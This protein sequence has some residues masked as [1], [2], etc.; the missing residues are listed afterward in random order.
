MRWFKDLKIRSKLFITFAVLAI[1]SG[2]VGAVGI[3]AMKTINENGQKIY[4]EDF[5]PSQNLQIIRTALQEVRANQLWVVYER[6]PETYPTRIDTINRLIEQ[7]NELLDDYETKIANDQDRK[8]FDALKSSLEEY[9]DTRD[10]SLKLI[11]DQK[12]EEALA[13][14][15]TV[16]ASRVKAD[17]A[18][19]AL[20]DFRMNKINDTLIENEKSYG[21]ETIIMLSF[22]A[23]GVVAALILGIYLS[24]LISKPINKMVRAAQQLAVGDINVEVDAT[25]KDEVGKLAEAFGIMIGSIRRQA[26]AVE[27]LATGDLTVEVEVRSEQDLL[28]IKLSEL[29]H[30]NNELLT[31]ISMAS[32][33]VADGS[34]Q[35]SDA[36]IALSSGA[37]E[38]ASA[39]EELTA[40]LEEISSQ[41]KQN[42]S[43]ADQ[44]NDLTGEAKRSAV[45]GNEHMKEMLKAMEEINESSEN[46]SKIIKVIDDIAFQ[47]NILALNAAVEAARAGQ[48]G[49]GFA[50]VAEEVRNLAARSAN[51]AKETTDMIESSIKKADGGTKIARDTAEAFQTI[52][53]RIEDI[54]GIVANIAL[55]SNEQSLGIEQINQGIM[56]VSQVIQTNSATSQEEA[57]ASEE[58][59]SQATILKEMVAQFKLRERR[60]LL[61][62]REELSPEILA[63]IENRKLHSYT[64][65]HPITEHLT[66]RPK[67]KLNDTEFGKY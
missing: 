61:S 2:I 54:A 46:I 11:A 55:A 67:I 16:T 65:N 9:R 8:L 58:L 27:K 18:L 25:T 66:D 20:I 59:Y 49:K 12:Y 13:D 10:A 15:A 62:G 24:N 7:T 22:V 6:N 5:V 36:S 30:K 63:L 21:R 33:Q 28:G 41:T 35:I 32:D 19:N 50:V 40:S 34:K 4:Y 43:N 26:Q 60:Q 29:I 14:M 52:V 64:E 17:E 51:A 39:I 31:N 3:G 1:F 42:A 57:A 23:I 45:K 38:Q 44:A 56:Q 47:T 53:N 37:T 48:H